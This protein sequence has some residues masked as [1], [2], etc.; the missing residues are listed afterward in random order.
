MVLQCL[1]RRFCDHH[2]HPALDASH[3]YV[4]VRVVR[5]EDNR[6]VSGLKCCSGLPVRRGRDHGVCRPRLDHRRVDALVNL[7]E[8][9]LH[10]ASDGRQLL[11]V[12]TDH[13]QAPDLA[14]LPKIQATKPQDARA[15]VRIS[16]LPSNEPRHVFT[17]AD[18]EATRRLG[19]A[20][21]GLERFSTSIEGDRR[22]TSSAASSSSPDPRRPHLLS[23]RR[24]TKNK[25]AGVKSAT[26]NDTM[27]A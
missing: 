17:S 12:H 2:V 13:A 24:A 9:F 5:R 19:R 16:A 1:H 3:R 18:H 4:V 27:E 14:P 8:G 15:F 23:R 22:G 20:T 21:L 7:A 11:P 6:D 25:V 26:R 10:V